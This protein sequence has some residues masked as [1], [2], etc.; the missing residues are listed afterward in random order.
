MG[1][2]CQVNSIVKLNQTEFPLA[3][4]IGDSHQVQKSGYRIYPID[5]PLQLVNRDWMAHGDVVIDKLIWADQTT[6][7]E[8]HI[9][10]LY[11]EPFPVKG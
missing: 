6:I 1:M 2:P 9:H 3:L 4:T 8:F 10:R 5:V 11:A 7:V